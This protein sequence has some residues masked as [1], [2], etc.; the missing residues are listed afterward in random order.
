MAEKGDQIRF[1]RGSYAGKT[2]WINKS[3]KKTKEDK[4][5]YVIVLMS[6]GEE[7]ETKAGKYNY[8]KL[9]E[10][11]RTYE[12][13][14]LQQHF[15]IEKTMVKLAQMF[16]EC[17][18]HDTKGATKLFEKELRRAMKEI[19][20]KGPDAR[21]RNVE[22]Q[23]VEEEENVPINEDHTVPEAYGGPREY[24]GSTYGSL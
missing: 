22:F 6:N 19:H 24:D 10:E 16:A 2:G 18:I 5:R 13:A 9:H 12:E 21:F 11:P 8:R 7:K 4:Q 23:E 20:S 14:A 15:Q 17:A 3:K 1:V